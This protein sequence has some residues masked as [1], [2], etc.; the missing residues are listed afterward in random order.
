MSPNSFIRK[1][2]FRLIA[3]FAIILMNVGALFLLVLSYYHYHEFHKITNYGLAHGK[4][5][6]ADVVAVFGNEEKNLNEISAADS[7][8][9]IFRVKINYKYNIDSVWYEN[10]DVFAGGY[11][12]NDFVHLRDASDKAALYRAKQSVSVYYN[13]EDPSVSVLDPRMVI[14]KQLLIVAFVLIVAGITF[15][16]ILIIVR[17]E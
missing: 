5:C 17:P 8:N 10:D 1:K 2:Q 15:A 9:A 13:P 16:L 7:E 12:S 4:I 14:N 3:F 11:A 6:M